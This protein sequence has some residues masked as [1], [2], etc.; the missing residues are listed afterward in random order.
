M[1]LWICD[2]W[3]L[4]A[5]LLLA[6]LAGSGCGNK[7]LED[8]KAQAQKSLD[9]AKQSVEKS[10]QQL[11]GAVAAVTQGEIKLTLDAPV[12]SLTCSARFTPPTGGRPG[13]LQIGT[14]VSSGPQSF[15]AI[16]LHAPTEI[17]TL[18]ALQG[19]TVHGQLFVAKSESQGHFQSADGKPLAVQIVKIENNVITCQLQNA[20]VVR[21][22]QPPVNAAGAQAA[23]PALPVSGTLVG[24]IRP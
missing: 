20:E 11:P 3:R 24:A 7:Q 15:P 13:L 2:R 16:Y 14:S 4:A 8:L 17:A 21:L 22:D 6:C 12:N 23:A 5:L 1:T 19:Q 9:E 18:Q 10:A